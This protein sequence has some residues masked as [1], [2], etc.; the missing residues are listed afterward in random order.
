MTW[1]VYIVQCADQSLYTGISKDIDRRIHEHNHED[2]KAAKYTR[3]R[4]P[5]K[6][7][8]AEACQD[9]STASRR[10]YELKALSRDKKFALIAS[11]GER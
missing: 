4:R 11:A 5:V 10:E 6:L 7:V 8:Y 2:K 1:Q 9:R 3:A